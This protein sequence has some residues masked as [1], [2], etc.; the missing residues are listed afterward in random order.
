MTARPAV[1]LV[2]ED[3]AG[4]SRAMARMIELAGMVALVYPSAEA[5]LANAPQTI[6]CAVLDVQLP[7]IDG[8]ALAERLPHAVPVIFVSASDE[9]ESRVRALPGAPRVFLAKPFS[10][11]ALIEALERLLGER[12]GERSLRSRRYL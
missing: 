4:M 8:I 3:D 10:G 11:Q 1:V 5:M 9:A 6:D 12:D 2:V 7:G